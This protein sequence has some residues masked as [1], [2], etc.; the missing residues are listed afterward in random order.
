MHSDAAGTIKNARTSL[1]RFL[2][3]KK[4]LNLVVPAHA[5]LFLS[6]C[7]GL[8]GSPPMT[9]PSEAVIANSVIALTD[10]DIDTFYRASA[11]RELLRSIP[12]LRI[13]SGRSTVKTSFRT[14]A[15]SGLPLA[16]QQPALSSEVQPHK[17][18]S[19]RSQLR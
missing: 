12:T 15:S 16:R 19:R 11:R 10:N 5:I 18:S 3:H 7:A 8:S 1:W 13:R 9:F 4:F 17:R 2:S 14:W 6:G